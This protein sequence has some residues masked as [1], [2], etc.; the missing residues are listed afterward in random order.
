[1]SNYIISLPYNRVTASWQDLVGLPD[2]NESE[3]KAIDSLKKYSNSITTDSL[4]SPDAAAQ[5]DRNKRLTEILKSRILF[6]QYSKS[7]DR[8][9]L[10]MDSLFH[11]SKADFMKLQMNNSHDPI[12]QKMVQEKAIASMHTNWTRTVTIKEYGRTIAKIAQINKM[13]NGSTLLATNTSIGKL[14][15]KTNFGASMYVANKVSANDFLNSLMQRFKDTAILLD[16]WGTWCGAC[17]AEMPHSKQLQ[18]DTKGLPVV[19]VYL[20]TESGSDKQKWES[21]VAELKQPGVHIFID[22]ALDAE[23]RNRFSFGGYPGYA[24]FNRKGEYQPAAFQWLAD[25]DRSKLFDLI[26]K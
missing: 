22:M 23:I 11:S 10:R 15:R 3:L 21:K 2:L 12:I 9:I 13:L 6:Q 17:L 4:K 14:V 16:L 18:L 8:S 19:F 24:F 1:L 5:K 25:I 7:T 26:Y 20:C